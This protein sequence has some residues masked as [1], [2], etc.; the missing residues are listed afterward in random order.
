[1]T[2]IKD[3]SPAAVEEI[4]R[5]FDADVLTKE[6]RPIVRAMMEGYVFLGRAVKEKNGKIHKLLRMIFGSKTEK[7]RTILPGSVRKARAGKTTPQ[8]HGRNGASSYKGGRKVTVSH[9]SLKRG[10]LCPECRKGKVYPTAPGVTVRITGNAPLIATSFSCEK[11]RCNGCGEM[12]TAHVPGEGGDKYDA[13]AGAMIALLKY[14]MGVPFHRLGELQE[15]MGVPL[16]ASTQWDIVERTARP[17]HPAYKELIR[18]A[19]SFITTT[20]R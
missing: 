3:L 15:S 8:G 12:F 19:R 20:R 14:G 4:F 2:E 17:A 1:M 18:Q 11:L 9:A 16:P 10:D 6:D 13:A 7:T 5:R